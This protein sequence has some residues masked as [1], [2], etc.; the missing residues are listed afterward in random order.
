MLG[1]PNF[2][3][4]SFRYCPVIYGK[5][6][7]AVTGEF[8]AGYG[9]NEKRALDSVKW[10][11]IKQDLDLHQV[12]GAHVKSPTSDTEF[13]ICE[14]Y[15]PSRVALESPL[16]PPTTVFKNELRPFDIER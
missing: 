15:A 14:C 13:G 6:H 5:A 3:M 10:L 4:I 16:K 1:I 7:I 12:I 2:D 8:P 9:G 11:S